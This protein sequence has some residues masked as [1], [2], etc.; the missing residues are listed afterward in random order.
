MTGTTRKIDIWLQKQVLWARR[1]SRWHPFK[2][3]LRG[4]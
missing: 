4:Y 3:I 1:D 2:A